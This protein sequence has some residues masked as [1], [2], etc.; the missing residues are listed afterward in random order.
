M[1]P[2]HELHLIE[3]HLQVPLGKTVGATFT[4][5]AADDDRDEEAAHHRW[6]VVELGGDEV[7]DDGRALRVP[8]QDDRLAVAM[9]EEPLP[10]G[11]H[12]RKR[13]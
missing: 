5:V 10:G 2:L 6:L 9:G 3:Q 8:N 1:A 13:R 11:E 12:C 7:D 4:K